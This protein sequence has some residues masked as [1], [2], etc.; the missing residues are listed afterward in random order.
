[1]RLL[2]KKIVEKC[3]KSDLDLEHPYKEITP[4][5][6]FTKITE[7]YGMDDYKDVKVDVSG[8]EGL[9]T[10]SVT[11]EKL[12]RFL[13]EAEKIKKQSEYDKK[14]LALR[15]RIGDQAVKYLIGTSI[16]PDE[17]IKYLPSREIIEKD[18]DL[19]YRCFAASCG[20]YYPEEGLLSI[21]LAKKLALG[22]TLDEYPEQ[23]I[24]HYYAYPDKTK[25]VCELPF[26]KTEFL[27]SIESKQ[28]IK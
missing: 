24:Y 11:K 7:Y 20:Y 6:I 16:D 18:Y 19:Y 12:L 17:L 5:D 21:E 23:L 4:Y 15:D 28:K 25:S 13:D 22:Q 3:L 10:I 26:T 1:M 8:E 9:I 2:P 27:E 14:F